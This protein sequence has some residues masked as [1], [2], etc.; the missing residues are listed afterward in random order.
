MR[1]VSVAMEE[2]RAAKHNPHFASA[3]ELFQL[4]IM[5][6]LGMDGAPDLVVAQTWLNL[7]ALKG[8][9]PARICR[10]ELAT[11]MTPDQVA[12]AQHQAGQLMEVLS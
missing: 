2:A 11:E 4:G 6:S 9:V 3:E 7:A 8:S 12:K 10:R 5:H 1:M